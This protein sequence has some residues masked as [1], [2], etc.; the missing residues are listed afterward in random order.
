MKTAQAVDNQQDQWPETALATVAQQQEIRME[1]P[2]QVQTAKD[3]R[4]NS[5]EVDNH[6]RLLEGQDGLA[7]GSD[8]LVRDIG[9]DGAGQVDLICEDSW[10]G[11]GRFFVAPSNA[12]LVTV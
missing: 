12:E 10:R 7:A 9:V 11:R 5:I 6:I 2:E 1:A 3:R 4:G 8:L